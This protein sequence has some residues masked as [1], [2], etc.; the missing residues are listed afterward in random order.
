M[1]RLLTSL[2]KL[3]NNMTLKICLFNVSFNGCLSVSSKHKITELKTVI[4]FIRRFGI[5]SAHWS[6]LK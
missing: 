5:K 1:N 6:V 3:P 2:H 4:I